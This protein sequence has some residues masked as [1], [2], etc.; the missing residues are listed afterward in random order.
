VV[1]LSRLPTTSRTSGT[2]GAGDV[3]LVWALA[4]LVAVV[5]SAVLLAALLAGL[6]RSAVVSTAGLAVSGGLFVLAGR[7]TARRRKYIG[8][9]YSYLYD[10]ERIQRYPDVMAFLR[11][12]LLATGDFELAREAN[13][14]R[15]KGLK[16][17]DHGDSAEWTTSVDLRSEDEA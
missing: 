16:E 7:L 6:P 5:S 15:V 14:A 2:P 12:R 8:D 11:N 17:Q 3:A 1:D 10:T 13:A 4:G 9:A